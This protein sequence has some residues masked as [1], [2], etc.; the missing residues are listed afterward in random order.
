MS[1]LL[2]L[3]QPGGP[4]VIQPVFEATPRAS[5]VSRLAAGRL[6][7]A[8]DGADNNRLGASVAYVKPGR[9]GETK[10]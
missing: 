7:F 6:G 3:R 5:Y 4:V 10:Q 8:A 9:V 2:L 1:L